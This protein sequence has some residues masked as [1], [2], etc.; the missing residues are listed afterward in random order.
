[1]PSAAAQ[2]PAPASVAPAPEATKPSISLSPAVI[3]AKG[4]FGQGLTQTLTLTNQTGR[5]FAFDLIAED[6]IIKDGKRIYVP[7]GETPNSIAATAVFSQKTVVVKSFS[8]AS[9]DVRLTLPVQTDIRAVVAMF[10]GTDKLP[11]STSSVGMTA[12]L[13]TLLTFNLTDNIKLQPE[14]VRV[15][16]AS[17]TANMTIAQWIANTGAEPA[18]PE[19]TAAVLNAG[20]SLVGK[21]TFAA[22]RLLPGERLE[23]SAEY[24]SDL[25]PG[26]YR[27]LCSYQ[28]EGKTL[29]S[30]GAFEVP[31]K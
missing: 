25:A 7:A 9:V 10:R 2:N 13:G 1:M 19:G 18:L 4:N 6:V 8:S 27:V 15:N 24:P 30:E 21:A 17:D 29:T 14:A 11:T 28:F 3:M 31:Q 12:S 22:Q 16:P 23:F 26:K 20:G 5:D